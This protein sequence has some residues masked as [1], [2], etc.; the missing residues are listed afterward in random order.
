MECLARIP[1]LA[2]NSPIRLAIFPPKSA[3]GPRAAL[4]LHFLDHRRDTTPCR[5]THVVALSLEGDCSRFGVI[6][7]ALSKFINHQH[8]SPADR[9]LVARDMCNPWNRVHV[10]LPPTRFGA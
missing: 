4:P 5:G 2:P 10:S 7:G 3:Y 8:G 6:G 9:A 1:P